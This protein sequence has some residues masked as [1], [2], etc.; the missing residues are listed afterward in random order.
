MTP[1]PTTTTSALG[2]SASVTGFA[3]VTCRRSDPFDT[4]VG[5]P[6]V[7]SHPPPPP[8]ARGAACKASPCGAVAAQ[9]RPPL[10]QVNLE[11]LWSCRAKHTCPPG[12]TPRSDRD[13]PA[14]RG[15]PAGTV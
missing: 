11:S 1:P 2:G 6:R 3:S 13:A 5:R 10:R 15:E 8:A 9:T 7:Y 14:R 12:R 4:Y